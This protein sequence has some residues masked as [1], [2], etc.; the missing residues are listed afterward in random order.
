MMHFYRI[1]QL[2][3]IT[4]DLGNLFIDY[5]KITPE[6]IERYKLL[7]FGEFFRWVATK[8]KDKKSLQII[9]G[10]KQKFEQ[11]QIETARNLLSWRNNSDSIHIPIRFWDHHK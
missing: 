7:D 11:L 10:A 6:R 4:L 1:S 9:K 8:I 5:R 2:E 3:I